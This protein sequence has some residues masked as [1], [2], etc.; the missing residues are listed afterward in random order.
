MHDSGV[1]DQ[2][3]ISVNNLISPL[4]N[5]TFNDIVKS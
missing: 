2:D 5:R 1:G 3:L 4:I